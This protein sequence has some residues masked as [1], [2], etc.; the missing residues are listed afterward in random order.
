MFHRLSIV[1]LWRDFF[2]ILC[3]QEVLGSRFVRVGDASG[4]VHVLTLLKIRV[5]EVAPRHVYFV[6]AEGPVLWY[7]RP[8]SCVSLSTSRLLRQLRMLCGLGMLSSRLRATPPIIL[9]R[10]TKTPNA[11]ISQANGAQ[12]SKHVV[13]LRYHFKITEGRVEIVYRKT[14]DMLFWFFY[15]DI[16]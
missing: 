11:S 16:V 1:R 15:Q 12:S 3:L 5:L 7:V 10:S 13:Y 14:L 6:V 9:S 2:G 8:E 4:V